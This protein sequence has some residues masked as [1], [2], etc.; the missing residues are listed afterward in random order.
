VQLADAFGAELVQVFD[1]KDQ[2]AFAGTRDTIQGRLDVLTNQINGLIARIGA[3]PPDVDQL[4][5]QLHA[6]QNQYSITY[7][8][9][10]SLAAQGPP[11][12]RFTM[13]ERAR[14]LRINKTEYNARRHGRA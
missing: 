1:Q 14:A 8:S 11:A 5:A 2:D 6:L 10:S 12:S 4:N 3:N 13:L 9:L 7:D